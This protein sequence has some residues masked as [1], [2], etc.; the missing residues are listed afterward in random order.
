MWKDWNVD[1]FNHRPQK[2]IVRHLNSCVLDRKIIAI[3]VC[4]GSSF[5]L[6]FI[7]NKN[8]HKLKTKMTSH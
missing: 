6:I 5:F 1:D 7:M 2:V 4:Q 8:I 3:T